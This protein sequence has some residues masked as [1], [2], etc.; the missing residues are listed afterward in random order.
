VFFPKK[1][2]AGPVPTYLFQISMDETDL[3]AAWR[4]RASKPWEQP[5]NVQWQFL[6]CTALRR[7]FGALAFS[8][9]VCFLYE[10]LQKK[11]KALFSY[12][13]ALFYSTTTHSTNVYW[14]LDCFYF[15]I[16]KYFT[17]C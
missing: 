2:F 13:I 4:G 10:K 7:T 6:R 12:S 16:L 5:E 14:R 3:C 17:F 8:S 11:S 1:L 15:R 9:N